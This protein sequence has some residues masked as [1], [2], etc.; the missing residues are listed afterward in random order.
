MSCWTGWFPLISPSSYYCSSGN[1]NTTT[2]TMTLGTTTATYYTPWRCRFVLSS[3]ITSSPTIVPP[4]YL[5]MI[6]VVD[7]SAVDVSTNK[8]DTS[9]GW[10]GW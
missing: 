9:T 10:N 7:S 4:D 2:T 3:M 8:L 1:S 6:L 5:R